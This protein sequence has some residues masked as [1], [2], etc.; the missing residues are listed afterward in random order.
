MVRVKLGL[1]RSIWRRGFAYC[2]NASRGSPATAEFLVLAMQHRG[3]NVFH[4]QRTFPIL[5]RTVS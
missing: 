5:H 3:W 2:R 4:D 1:R